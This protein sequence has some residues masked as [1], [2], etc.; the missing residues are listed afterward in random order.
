[1]KFNRKFVQAALIGGA[2]SIAMAT[3]AMAA[4]DAEFKIAAGELRSALTT[5][6]DQSG[7]QLIYRVDDVRGAQT[8][9][10][11]GRHESDDALKILLDDTGFH[12]QWDRSGAAVV[13]K[14]GLLKNA[15]QE[16]SSFRLAQAD[17]GVSGDVETIDDRDADEKEEAK[18][19]IV[20]TGS[21]I[22]GA[23]PVGSQVLTFDRDDID[24]K[25]YSTIPQF[26]QSLPQNF[27]GGIS[28]STSQLSSTGAGNLNDGTGINLRGLGNVST[29]VLLNGQ[30]LAPSGLNGSFADISMIP[31]SAI[32]RVEVLTDGAS[33]IYGSDAVGGVVNFIMRKDYDGAETRIRYGGATGG[34]LEEVLVGQTFGKVWEKGHGLI[35]YEYSYRDRLDAKDRSFTK[36][37]LAPNDLLPEQE[38]NNL[39]L[40][41]GH[42]LTKELEVFTT[43]YYNQRSSERNQFLTPIVPSTNFLINTKT[44]NYGGSVGSTLDLDSSL[45]AAWQA[46][47]VGSYSRSDSIRETTVLVEPISESTFISRVS[48]VLSVDANL[49]G[50][51]FHMEGGDAKLAIGGHY[52]QEKLENL[53][54][55]SVDPSRIS[56]PLNDDFSRNVT[57]VYG[58]VYLPLVG[59]DNRMPGVEQLEVS[60]SGRYEHYSDFGSSTNPKVGVL[61][62][63]IAG[64][65]LRGTYGAS[66]RAPLLTEL[67]EGNNRAALIY[68]PL[69]GGTD[70]VILLNGNGNQNIRPETATLWTAGFDLQPESIP[71]I[72]VNAT[73]FNID[74]RDKIAAPTGL[75]VF[76]LLGDPR[77]ASITDFN[78]PDAELFVRIENY[79]LNNLTTLPGLGPAA[80]F[81]DANVVFN[82]LSQNLSRN[83]I[84]GIDFS[85]VYGYDSDN[86]GTWN[87]SL[88]GTYLLEFQ[89]QLFETDPAFDLVGLINNPVQLRMNGGVSW[90]YEGFTTNFTVNYTDSYVDDRIEPSVPIDSWTTANLVLNYNTAGRV[91]GLLSDTIF[92]L[93][94][95][96]IF[97]QDPPF[98]ETFRV[99]T[100]INYDPS[101]ASPAGRVLSFQITKQW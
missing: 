23:G 45:G 101:A 57:A 99:D 100:N 33:A 97:N 4:E 92:S 72:R 12:A 55:T 46:E 85:V 21:H 94:A 49:D 87:F 37:A 76:N 93:S 5:Y 79:F 30:R 20:V 14:T 13:V 9:G 11:S 66:F 80:T 38:R 95:F 67:D 88:N 35:S 31:L 53:D 41:G 70:L 83:N 89:E 36:D 86:F 1:M 24:I 71:Q 84:S 50:H 10:V 81:A 78:G 2:S 7:E 51:I 82:A 26:I 43:V 73:Y 32:E 63:P 44:K 3:A 65:N 90:A 68:S 96:N 6:I 60:I 19:I 48:E 58:E 17:T 27:N 98:V 25:G 8:K 74:Y 18:D 16:V 29:L 69:F 22:R 59:T 28:E 52:R 64:L 56:S 15:S 77:F 75:N 62:S 42:N 40:T 91:D 47:V 39:F 54:L 34:G 61:W